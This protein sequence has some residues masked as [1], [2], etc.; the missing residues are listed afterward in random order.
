MP[1][2]AHAQPF[3]RLALREARVGPEKTAEKRPRTAKSRSAKGMIPAEAGSRTRHTY[4]RKSY[5]RN[6]AKTARKRHRT[7]IRLVFHIAAS[8]L[9]GQPLGLA[10]GAVDVAGGEGRSAPDQRTGCRRND[11][12]RRDD[13]VP[14]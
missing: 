8:I 7:K 9:A 1:R 5:V 14:G 10:I 12:G 4:D 2:P 11:V 13:R 6:A 3:R